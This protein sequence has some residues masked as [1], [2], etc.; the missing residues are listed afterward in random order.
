MYFFKVL[1]SSLFFFIIIIP[2]A[3]AIS[4]TNYQDPF[5]ILYEFFEAIINQL[6]EGFM[7]GEYERSI[8]IHQL[9]L[10]DKEIKDLEKEI[11]DI[12]KDTK[13]ILKIVKK[14]KK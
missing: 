2:P 7:T 5:A 13:E 1:T 10:Q 6:T 3:H 4:E 12:K 9:E 8:I 14:L 11:K